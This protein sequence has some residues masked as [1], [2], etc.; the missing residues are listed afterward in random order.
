MGGNV[1]LMGELRNAYKI[2]W[3]R[4]VGKLGIDARIILKCTLNK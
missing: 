1:A 4:A 2:V 3:I